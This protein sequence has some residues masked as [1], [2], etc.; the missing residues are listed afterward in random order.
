MSE[1]AR[2][3]EGLQTK[4]EEDNMGYKLMQAMGYKPG[5]TLGKLSAVVTI[6]SST[7]SYD[8][9]LSYNIYIYMYIIYMNLKL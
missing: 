7:I 3:E 9:S 5:E 2:R 8:L 4:I 6:F 1:K